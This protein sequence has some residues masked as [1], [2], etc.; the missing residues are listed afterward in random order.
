VV[1]DVTMEGS[2]IPGGLGQ[3]CLGLVGAGAFFSRGDPT[4]S[5][6]AVVAAETGSEASSVWRPMRPTLTKS[7]GIKRR[8]P[9]RG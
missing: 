8:R 1:V 4:I 3:S 5:L 7:R 9:P 6:G 2:T